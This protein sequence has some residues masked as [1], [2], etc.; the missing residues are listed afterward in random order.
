MTFAILKK[1]VDEI[2]KLLED[3]ERNKTAPHWAEERLRKYIVRDYGDYH[4]TDG[5]KKLAK[6][7]VD[8]VSAEFRS[9]AEA[10]ARQKDHEIQMRIDALR[11]LLPSAAAKA[12]IELCGDS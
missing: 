6:E 3:V 2:G 4:V 5:D 10:E 9:R 1:Y 12:A 11:V 7:A 8:K